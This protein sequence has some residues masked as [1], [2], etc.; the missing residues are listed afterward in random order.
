MEPEFHCLRCGQC[1]RHEGEVRLVD[2]EATAIAESLGLEPAD[3][4]EQFTRLRED[5]LGLSLT[6]HPDGSCIFLEGTPP[7]CRIQEAKPRQ[8]REFPH[9]WRYENWVEICAAA[10]KPE[11]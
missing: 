10:Q 9:S 5:R 8:C 6:D 11:L 2:G 1:C 7:S 4:A 3:F